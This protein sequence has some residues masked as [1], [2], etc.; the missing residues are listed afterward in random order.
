M[1]YQIKLRKRVIHLRGALFYFYHLG[2][3]RFIDSIERA[4]GLRREVKRRGRP[5]KTAAEADEAQEQLALRI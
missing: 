1:P 5:K 4:T 2:Y 3:S